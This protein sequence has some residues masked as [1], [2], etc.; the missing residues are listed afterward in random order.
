M[1]ADPLIGYADLEAR[2][3]AWA[4]TQPALRAAVAIDPRTADMVP[5]TKGTL[6]V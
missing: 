1:P 3:A 4:Q 2:F 5:S 6:S